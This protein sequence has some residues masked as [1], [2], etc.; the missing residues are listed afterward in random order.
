ME[1]I[2]SRSVEYFVTN[3]LTYFTE[4]Q[5]WSNKAFLFIYLFFSDMIKTVF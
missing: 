2:I 4:I 1:R 3:N 5:M